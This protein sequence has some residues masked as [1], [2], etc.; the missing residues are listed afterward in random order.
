MGN[1]NLIG[2]LEWSQ[3]RSW[4]V[5]MACTSSCFNDM[6]QGFGEPS[7]NCNV[8]TVHAFTDIMKYM[9][10][11]KDRD[12]HSPSRRTWARGPCGRAPPYSR[13]PSGRTRTTMIRARGRPGNMPDW[14]S[15]SPV[16]IFHRYTSTTEICNSL[17]LG[18]SW[19]IKLGT[20]GWKTS[21][22]VNTPKEDF[23]ACL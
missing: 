19:G 3:H 10:W 4:K 23:P 16:I 13:G 22:K 9:A 21:D 6:S 14:T 2:H 12:K 18:C 7:R 8:F 5:M 20:T 1:A 15:P 17:W 11:Y